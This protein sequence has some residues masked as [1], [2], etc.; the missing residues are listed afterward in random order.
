MNKQS[1]AQLQQAMHTPRKAAAVAS[2]I[3]RAMQA[4]EEVENA[5]NEGSDRKVGAALYELHR[6][7]KEANQIVK[8]KE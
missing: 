7:L 5:L 1:L 2:L 8:I 4:L 3:E 6:A